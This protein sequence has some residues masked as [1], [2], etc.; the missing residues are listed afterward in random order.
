MEKTLKSVHSHVCSTTKWLMTLWN[1]VTQFSWVKSD[2]FSIKSNAQ[3]NTIHWCSMKT[4][5]TSK[6]AQIYATSLLLI[7][8]P[9][10]ILCTSILLTRVKKTKNKR[11]AHGSIARSGLHTLKS[12]AKLWVYTELNCSQSR[13]KRMHHVFWSPYHKPRSSQMTRVIHPWS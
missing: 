13:A 4:N 8:A 7:C 5:K 6:H 3:Q 9:V 2:V 1:K 10:F 11:N 12:N